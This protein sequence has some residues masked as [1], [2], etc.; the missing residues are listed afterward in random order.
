MRAIWK[1]SISFGLVNIPISLHP[2]TRPGHEIKLRL[3]RAS[4]HSLVRYKRIAEADNQEVPW[5]QIVKGYEYDKGNFV[6]LSEKDFERVNLKSTQ[7]IEIQEFVDLDEI[8][9]MFFDKPYILVPEKGGAKA[10][11]LLRDALK[12]TNKIGIAKMVLK[13]REYVAA[14]KPMSNA[15]ILEL[16]HFAD[17]LADPAL[18]NTATE[19]EISKKE[20]EMAEALISTMTGEWKPEKYKDEYADA[21]MKVID[22][23]ISS[24][25]KRLPRPAKATTPSNVVNLVDMLQKSLNQTRTKIREKKTSRSSKRSKAA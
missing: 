4:D 17:E 23:K 5:D 14:V 13:T 24:G 12:Q 2:A 11:T 20:R 18:L 8:D 3:L 25:H 15:L 19:V 1:G 6:V 7:T 21:L 22:V 9:P 10:Y 16:M